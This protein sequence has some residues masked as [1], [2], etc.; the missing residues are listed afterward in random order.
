MS[1]K[2]FIVTIFKNISATAVPYHKEVTFILDRIRA[3]TDLPLINQIRLEPDKA[4]RNILKKGLPSICFSGKFRQRS[5]SGLIAHSGLICI[6][7]DG[8]KD[9]TE[10]ALYRKAFLTSPEK[11]KFTF[12]LF[13]SPSGDGLKIIIRIPADASAHK[14]YFKAL[15]EFYNDSHFDIS[16]SDVSRVCYAS[17][18]ADLYYNPD[19]EIW[20]EREINEHMEF[21]TAVPVLKLKT[22]ISIVQNLQKW[23]T[24]NYVLKKGEN[25]NASLFIFASAFNDFGLPQHVAEQYIQSKYGKKNT[26]KEISLLVKS[27]YK[28]PG[29]TKFFEDK[30]GLELIERSVR[31]GTEK[32]KILK[33]MQD[34]GGHSEEDTENAIKLIAASLPISEFWWFDDMGRCRIYNHKFKAFL[35]QNGFYKLYPEGSDNFIF[36]RVDNNMIENVTCAVVKD[37]VLDYLYNQP[38]IS[39]YETMSGNAKYFK[40][41]Y[42]NLIDKADVA[43]YEDTVDKC[44]VYFKNGAAIV[45][46]TSTP[47]KEQTQLGE[48]IT[49]KKETKVELVDYLNLPGYVWRKHIIER[50]YE[51]TEWEG[52]V[53]DRFI[54]CIAGSDKDKILSIK[55]TIGYLMH[56]FKTS[57]NNK[58]VILND[59]TISDNPNGGSGKGILCHAVSKMKRVSILDGKSFDGNK[60]FAYQT[61]SADCQ[62]L[63]YDD[64]PRNFPFENLFSV[65]TEGITLEK[66]NK[67]AIHLPVSKS[68]KIVIN[69]NYTIGG[70]GGS[71]D[72]RKWEVEFSSFFNSNHT[73]LNEFGHQLFDEWS[74]EEWK[75]FDCMMI[76]CVKIFLENGL[77]KQEFTNLAERKFIKETSFDFHEWVMDS[78][79]PLHDHIVKSEWFNKFIKEYP[80]YEKSKWFT[81]KR[82]S[83]WLEIYGRY[84]GFRQVTGKSMDGRWIVF[85]PEGHTDAEVKEIIKEKEKPTSQNEEFE[86]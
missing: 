78:P 34:E 82:F 65:V 68:P 41:D 66:K 7:F 32:K 59:E 4:K 56:S 35:E 21:S 5:A 8:F 11:K 72:R 27:A 15:K 84:K 79:I 18:D 51:P 62:V 23:F 53:F 60:S 85:L 55:S 31:A 52:C 10:L 12:A 48:R 20:V 46:T 25:V 14:D 83:Q 3:G 75:K 1:N 37:F 43:F 17:A 24:K 71:F 70:V 86:F 49:Q 44:V 33:K 40:D 6:D 50:D 9:E 76:D 13:T 64:V 47:V 2:G 63:V 73:P 61:V 77:V 36:V 19:S 67:D 81:Q 74:P 16:T 38:N 57:A 30:Q 42:L 45:K 26:E 22:E 58:A 80:D 39:P 28:K 29:G 54:T 69:T